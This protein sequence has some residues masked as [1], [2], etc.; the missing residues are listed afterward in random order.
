[1]EVTFLKSLTRARCY[2]PLLRP[3]HV[4]PTRQAMDFLSQSANAAHSQ[5]SMVPVRQ[6][7]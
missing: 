6:H 5:R 3:C 1:M 4:M 2:T 7:R